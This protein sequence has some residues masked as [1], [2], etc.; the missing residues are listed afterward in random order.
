LQHSQAVK[1]GASGVVLKYS[2]TAVLIESIRNVYE[3]GTWLDPEI[4]AKLI[5][6]LTSGEP[7][8]Q[9]IPTEPVEPPIRSG[10]PRDKG[11]AL[12]PRER[13][14]AKLVAQGFKNK[15]IAEKV[16][17]SEQ[18][19]KNHLHNIFDKLRV[20]DRLELALYVIN[21]LDL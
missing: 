4:T 14:V 10:R 1:L 19:V 9:S 15:D 6:Q 8:P 13:E 12:S 7:A 3:G 2:E 18:T 17:I 16:F 20:A 21:N 11:S 5:R